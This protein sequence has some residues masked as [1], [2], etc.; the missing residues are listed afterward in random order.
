MRER[1][2]LINPSLWDPHEIHYEIRS[3][4]ISINPLSSFWLKTVLARWGWNAAR[5]HLLRTAN[6]SNAVRLLNYAFL[7]SW[8]LMGMFGY[9]WRPRH[10][11]VAHCPLIPPTYSLLDHS[12]MRHGW[13]K[14]FFRSGTLILSIW[15]GCLFSS[16][17]L[18]PQLPI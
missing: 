15:L 10:S 17:S 12:Q 14:Y 11:L 5:R 2:C 6:K 13:L 8:C 18:T 3:L 1:I 9:Y 16:H 4:L 7:W